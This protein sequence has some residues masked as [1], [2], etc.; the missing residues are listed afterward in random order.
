MKGRGFNAFREKDERGE[1]KSIREAALIY[2]F[3]TYIQAFLQAAG[4]KSYREAHT[5]L[6]RSDLIINVAGE[7]YLIE[8]KIYYYELQFVNG[9]KQLAY[10]SRSLGQHTGIYLVFCPN[11]I[12]YPDVVKESVE[13]IE[14]VEIHTWLVEYDEEKWD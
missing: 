1:Y 8:T 6:G 10:Y 7:E 11:N 9:K 2:S 4:G 14:G 13:T 12:R 5:G 3:E